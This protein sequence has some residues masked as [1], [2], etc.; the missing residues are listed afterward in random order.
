MRI[1]HLTAALALS[2]LF[3]PG[4]GESVKPGRGVPVSGTVTL[5]GKPLADADV[6][7]TNDTFVGVAKTDAEGKYRLVQGALP[8]KNRVSVSKYEGGAAS[9]L[10]DAQPTGEGLDAGQAAA[11]QMGWGS[12]KKKAA[13]PKQLVPA[14]YSDPTTTKLTYDIPAAGTDGVDFNL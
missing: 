10:A 14:D 3:L 7:F 11:A 9:P 6:I 5:G 8:G 2:L 13:G 1:Q 4:C 12:E